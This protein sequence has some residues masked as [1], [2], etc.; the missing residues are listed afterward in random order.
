MYERTSELA[1]A[2]L[3]EPQAAPAAVIFFLLLSLLKKKTDCVFYAFDK[4]HTHVKTH[5]RAEGSKDHFA[6]SV[7]CGE[8]DGG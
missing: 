6:K 4:S 5:T 8:D 7:R 2:A 1:V 3:K